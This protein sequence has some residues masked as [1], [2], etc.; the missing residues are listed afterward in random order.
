MEICAKFENDNLYD[1]FPAETEIHKIDS[2]RWSWYPSYDMPPMTVACTLDGTDGYTDAGRMGA[3]SRT[4]SAL[5]LKGCI[6]E[7]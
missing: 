6:Q 1:K 4:V 2:W 5:T 7:K 3:T